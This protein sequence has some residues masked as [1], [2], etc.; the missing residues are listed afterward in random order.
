MHF[1]PLRQLDGLLRLCRIARELDLG[2]FEGQRCASP[3]QCESNLP[4]YTAHGKGLLLG[5]AQVQVR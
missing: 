5:D 1:S 2:C 3:P 4:G